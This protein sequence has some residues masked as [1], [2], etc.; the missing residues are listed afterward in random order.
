MRFHWLML[1]GVERARECGSEREM[2]T[3]EG[4][5]REV[6][7][8]PSSTNDARYVCTPTGILGMR[9]W[10]REAAGGCKGAS[11]ARHVAW[12]VE[13]DSIGDGACGS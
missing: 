3:S 12:H 5:D 4:D 10:M 11:L 1:K 7:R 9:D 6:A 8:Q 2:C 13:K